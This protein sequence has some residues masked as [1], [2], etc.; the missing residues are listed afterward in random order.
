[1]VEE[2]KWTEVPNRFLCGA[3]I[4][5][6]NIGIGVGSWCED[7]GPMPS[8]THSIREKMRSIYSH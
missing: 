3:V 7:G 4:I 1:M 2:G 5:S 6:R 8:R